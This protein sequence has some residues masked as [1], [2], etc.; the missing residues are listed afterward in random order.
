MSTINRLPIQSAI[1]L[2]KGLGL[3]NFSGP[4]AF[5]SCIA[6]LHIIMSVDYDVYSHP[7]LWASAHVRIG[8][9]LKE[10]G[11]GNHFLSA[12]Q[13]PWKMT[14][15]LILPKPPQLQVSYISI[16]LRL[17]S[18]DFRV[19][20]MMSIQLNIVIMTTIG[21][22]LEYDILHF[23]IQVRLKLALIRACYGVHDSM[24][25]TWYKKSTVNQL[26]V[27]SGQVGVSFY[28]FAAMTRYY[29]RKYPRFKK[30][31]FS[32]QVKPQS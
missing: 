26:F 7:H 27:R 25:A 9:H 14:N 22:L 1:G 3:K 16:N 10:G 4:L 15:I 2:D 30:G 18:P 31:W 19:G 5:T 32:L 28:G 21:Q 6:T 13:F 29:W 20:C 17:H 8:E 12:V 11:K 24:S 23:P